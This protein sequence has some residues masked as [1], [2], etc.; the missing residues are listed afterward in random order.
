LPDNIAPLTELVGLPMTSANK[1]AC[2]FHDDV[3]PSCAIYPDHFKCFACGEH[4]G[5]LD[6]LT[7]AEGMTEAEAIAFIKDWPG[8]P[9]RLPAEANGNGTEDKLAFAK[10]VWD[11]AQPLRGSII[12]RYLD[13]TRQIDTTKLPADIHRNLRFHPHCVFGGTFV[14]CLIA[15]MRDPLTGKPCGIQRTALEVRDGRIEKTD[16]RMLGRAGVVMIWPAG[17]QLVLG[18]GLETVLAAATRIPYAGA[19]LTPAW[20]ALSSNALRRFPVI[21]G[22]ERLIIL[23]DNDDPGIAA[24]AQCK[25]RWNGIGRT[26]IELTPEA[27]GTD[28]NDL[29]LSG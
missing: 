1:V 10:S 9:S 15:L 23:V 14:P 12:E 18:E 2:P 28:F 3:T 11:S 6:W 13:E 24:A 7:R 22:V 29:V 4:G 27:K 21:T 25:A 8:T 19:P 5:W 16:R 26:V 17:K 20:A